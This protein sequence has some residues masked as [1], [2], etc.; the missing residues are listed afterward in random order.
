MTEKTASVRVFAMD[1][2]LFLISLGTLDCDLHA[3]MCTCGE[4]MRQKLLI[5]KAK[6][7]LSFECDE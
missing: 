5:K 7:L 3:G 6:E 4:N 2:L 1:T